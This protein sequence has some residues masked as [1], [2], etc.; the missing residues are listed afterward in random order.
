MTILLLGLSALAG[1]DHHEQQQQPG[2]SHGLNVGSQEISASEPLARA[3]RQ[4]PDGFEQS[5]PAQ[6]PLGLFTNL[7]PQQ[8][9][10]IQSSMKT[11][12]SFFSSNTPNQ[13]AVAGQLQQAFQPSSQ[14]QHPQSAAAL[15]SQLGE[16]VRASQ[17]NHAKLVAKSQQSVQ[18]AIREGQQQAQQGL[19]SIVPV[20][21]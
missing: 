6:N 10:P 18:Q 20:I 21:N 19:G 13:Q 1:A 5:A 16:M 11:F 15:M 8:S 2:C 3:R 14:A 4:Q 7:G 17:M 12:T 9:E